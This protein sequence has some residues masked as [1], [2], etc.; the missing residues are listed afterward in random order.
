MITELCSGFPVKAHIKEHPAWFHRFDAVWTPTVLLLDAAGKER[1]RLE[2]YLPNNDFMAALKNG[3]G[4]I[5]FVQ[6][7]YGDAERWYGDVV[8]RCGD[9]HFAARS[10]VLAGRRAVQRVPRSHGPGQRR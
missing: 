8:A 6:K 9:S 10:D 5:A 7:K 1:V 3:L 2:G 4:R